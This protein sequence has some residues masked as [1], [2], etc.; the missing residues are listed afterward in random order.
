MHIT[1][2]FIWL[3]AFAVL[4]PTSA[5]ASDDPVRS[6]EQFL[7]ASKESTNTTTS[8]F[9]NK[10][11]NGWVKQRYRV[12]EL[13]FDV[14]KTDSLV[15]PIVGLVTLDLLTEASDA[16]PSQ[17]EAEK[18]ISFNVMASITDRM[19]LTYAYRDSKWAFSKGS[20]EVLSPS[21]KGTRF[22][23]TDDRLT[24]QPLPYWLPK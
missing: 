23:L 6:F 24:R 2:L 7:M 11:K 1:R 15:T 8:V 13:K 22:E 21:L 10:H 18:L 5:T 3:S 9:F 20:Y 19:S 14:K 12:V 4:F 16:F 17:E